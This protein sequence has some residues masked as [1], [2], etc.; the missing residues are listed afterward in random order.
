MEVWEWDGS[1]L[2]IGTLVVGAGQN[3]NAWSG[4]GTATGM[5]DQGGSEQGG[6]KLSIY[7]LLF[8]SLSGFVP[9]GTIT[10]S[11]TCIM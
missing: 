1:R 2:S 6:T 9:F 3:M 11:E 8:L 10:V 4:G 7:L 5:I